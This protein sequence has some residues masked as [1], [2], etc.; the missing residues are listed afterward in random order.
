MEQTITITKK[1]QIYI[2]LEIRKQLQLTSAGQALISVGNRNI[3]IKPVASRIL[4][5]AGK[6]KTQARKKKISIDRL[7]D[8]IDYSDL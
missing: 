5:M 3:I 2:P 7:R 8:V 6:Y 4:G 1:W